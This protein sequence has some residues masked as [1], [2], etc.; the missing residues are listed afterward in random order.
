MLE[1]MAKKLSHLEVVNVNSSVL[2]QLINRPQHKHGFIEIMYVLSGSVTN[3]IENQS[4]TYT[5]GSCCVMNSNICHCELFEGD[6]QIVFFMFQDEFLR[7]ILN[8]YMEELKITE[9]TLKDQPLFQLFNDTITSAHN[10]L[11][12]RPVNQEYALHC[13]LRAR[14]KIFDFVCIIF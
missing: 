13:V 8:E 11:Q 2:Q 9:K 6:F 10:L 7:V 14:A 1:N 12:R 4:F 5:E 3:R